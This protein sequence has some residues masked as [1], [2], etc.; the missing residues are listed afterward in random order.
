MKSLRRIL[1]ATCGVFVLAGCGQPQKE[2]VN[3]GIRS[4]IWLLANS[5]HST[6]DGQTL[7]RPMLM[8]LDVS[9]NS[10]T[11]EK[12]LFRCNYVDYGFEVIS[13]AREGSILR[14]GDLEMGSFTGRKLEVNL[15]FAA[16]TISW[17]M[18]RDYEPYRETSSNGLF[19]AYPEFRPNADPVPIHQIYTGKLSLPVKGTVHAAR[20]PETTI[21]YGYE[22]DLAH[23]QVDFFDP[24][25][26]QFRVLPEATFVGGDGFSFWPEIN[27][28]PFAAEKAEIQIGG[29]ADPLITWNMEAIAKEDTP[30]TIIPEIINPDSLVY[31]LH[32][33]TPPSHGNVVI[34]DAAASGAR[35]VYTPEPDY[36][37]SDSFTYFA[38]SPQ[39]TSKPAEVTL[40][41]IPVDDPPIAGDL[42]IDVISD[43]AT[44]IQLPISDID[45]PLLTCEVMTP[46][47]HGQ[48]FGNFPNFLYIP[49]PG[50]SQGKD[51]FTYVTFDFMSQS[52]PG[53]V[54]INIIP[55]PYPSRALA[56]HLTS[57]V[58]TVWHDDWQFYLRAGFF[59]AA[60]GILITGFGLTSQILQEPE[61]DTFGFDVGANN[62]KRTT[63]FSL[64]FKTYFTTT[65]FAAG[66][67]VYRATGL[68]SEKLVDIPAPNN[69]VAGE[70]AVGDAYVEGENAYLAVHWPTL[71]GQS[72]CQIWK[73]NASS[74]EPELVFSFAPTKLPGSGLK[75]FGSAQYMFVGSNLVQFPNMASAPVFIKDLG[76]A[77]PTNWMVEAG[78]KLF[79]Q[80][81]T[82]VQGNT[83]ID[84]WVTD[85]TEA[86][87]Q[88]VKELET[89]F[90]EFDIF[91]PVSFANKLYFAHRKSLWSSDGTAAGT[92]VVK[93]LSVTSVVGDGAIG[94]ISVLGGRLFFLAT[95]DAAG[96]EP[97]V[98]DGTAAGTKML[99]DIRVGPEKSS[100]AS[101][102]STYFYEW[103]GKIL[104]LANDGADSAGLWTTNGTSAGTQLLK[105]RAMTT[106]LGIY[107][108]ELIY[109][110]GAYVFGM[111][112]F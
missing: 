41:I 42:T 45:S 82:S 76:N 21:T 89:A 10:I 58:S 97:W 64:A 112:L 63:F 35:F 109:H 108:N 24:L 81:R 2:E 26:G 57:S 60:P 102:N 37:G 83:R 92:N 84:L 4:G 50:F 105:K 36:N 110:D 12:R 51:S 69:N 54:N 94:S 72:L 46:P 43:D 73:V 14:K 68:L 25:T 91:S 79:F 28:K 74:Y 59:G 40:T 49:E 107:P 78:G 16:G 7:C 20:L 62:A 53:I 1:V 5:R 100:A 86:G 90:V 87:T 77:E 52:E 98:S 71:D 67:R 99:R 95:T 11:L 47:E 70:P 103:N 56:G 13:Y 33:A 65:T 34:D 29:K 9:E 23:G 19:V 55:G 3:D 104:F 38:D 111:K 32:I 48:I 96:R 85:G 8:R 44:P 75:S 106:I 27:G 39:S 22:N 6:S 30:E 18:D 66:L 93:T 17:D 80:T 61:P 31:S 88:I 101:T 15:P